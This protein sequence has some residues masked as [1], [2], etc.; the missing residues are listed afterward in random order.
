[1]N[2]PFATLV[3]GPFRSTY[4]NEP[5]NDRFKADL[6]RY[7][8]HELLPQV[9]T[10]Y[11]KTEGVLAAA[12]DEDRFCGPHSAIRNIF[13]FE[14]RF[15]AGSESEHVKAQLIYAPSDGTFSV[16]YSKPLILWTTERKR[17][18]LE[19]RQKIEV[20]C[21][22]ILCGSRKDADCP[23]CGASVRVIDGDALFDVSCPIADLFHCLAHGEYAVGLVFRIGQPLNQFPKTLQG[24]LML[25]GQFVELGEFPERLPRIILGVGQLLQKNLLRLLI[26]ELH[27]RSSWR[28]WN[29]KAKVQ[30]LIH[31]QLSL[32]RPVLIASC[33]ISFLAVF[34][35]T[36]GT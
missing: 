22:E 35:L 12:F 1:M 15:L 6:D 14:F 13:N 29:L 18:Q 2:D 26:G 5:V 11:T 10:T 7:L 23:I 20:I 36:N 31:A 32:K 25:L 8:R 19:A 24:L 9:Q 4:H 27:D 30:S 3:V 33:Q 16:R 28:S 17:R 34:K 21:Q